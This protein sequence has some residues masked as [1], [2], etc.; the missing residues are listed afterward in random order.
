MMRFRSTDIVII[1]ARFHNS[2]YSKRLVNLLGIKNNNCFTGVA[3]SYNIIL[4]SLSA[5]DRVV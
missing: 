1:N 5:N 2:Q 3:L 4:V